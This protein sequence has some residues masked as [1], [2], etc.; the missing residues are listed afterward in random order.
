MQIWFGE[1]Y[2]IICYKTFQSWKYSKLNVD[3][4]FSPR[5]F[6]CWRWNVNKHSNRKT[7]RKITL[8][9]IVEATKVWDELT[10]TL[11][12]TH[13]ND[14]QTR[15]RIKCADNVTRVVHRSDWCSVILTSKPMFRQVTNDTWRKGTIHY[16]PNKPPPLWCMPSRAPF[17][18]WKSTDRLNSNKTASDGRDNPIGVYDVIS[19]SIVTPH[20]L[21]S[22]HELIRVGVYRR[23]YFG[24]QSQV[25]EHVSGIKPGNSMQSNFYMN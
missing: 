5:F 13:L 6:F 2:K 1:K 24:G 4:H 10:T 21:Y 18:T 25:P 15:A 3:D 12:A 20:C 22:V 9:R 11:H 23:A 19:Q 16:T 8:A 17:A 7:V 14:S